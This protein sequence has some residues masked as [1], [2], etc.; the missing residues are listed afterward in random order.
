MNSPVY[1]PSWQQSPSTNYSSWPE[2]SQQLASFTSTA[3]ANGDNV[4]SGVDPAIV[5]AA[6]AHMEEEALPL[7]VLSSGK[8]LT[9]SDTDPSIPNLTRAISG[10]SQ[11]SNSDIIT[12][13]PRQASISLSECSAGAE[14]SVITS[15]FDTAQWG[16]MGGSSGINGI[17]FLNTVKHIAGED[18]VM[19]DL[20]E[21][22]FLERY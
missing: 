18:T 4:S 22:V 3:V 14:S 7:D 17:K 6:L 8:R 16:D 21:S 9:S 15:Q 11:T 19:L 10:V 2:E 13:R 5:A 1:I 12:G 20:V